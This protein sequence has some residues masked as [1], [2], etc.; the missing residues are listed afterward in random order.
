MFTFKQN[1][2]CKCTPR[3]VSDA[4]CGTPK[5]TNALTTADMRMKIRT[6]LF[7]A[8]AAP[9]QR[10]IS[11]HIYIT[12]HLAHATASGSYGANGRQIHRCTH[13]AE[14]RRG[15]LPR[16]F[17]EGGRLPTSL[18]ASGRVLDAAQHVK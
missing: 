3:L 1:L 14:R 5:V 7:K 16:L 11:G 6:I 18:L 12:D 10:K 15:V 9:E 8:R 13:A 4:T 17:G 2:S